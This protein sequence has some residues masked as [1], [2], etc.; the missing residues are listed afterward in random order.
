MKGN[1]QESGSR[2][3]S[4]VR[5]VMAAVSLAVALYLAFALLFS[6]PEEERL[7]RENAQYAR[8]YAS[9]REREQLIGD[10]TKGLLEKDGAIYRELFETEA[11]S[12]NPTTAADL[13]PDSDSLS[14]SFYVSAASSKTES[15]MLMAGNVDEAFREIFRALEQRR[16]SVPPLTLPLRGMSYVQTGASAGLKHNPVYKVEMQHDGIDL[17]VPQGEPVYAAAD[18]AVTEVTHSRKGLGNQVVIDHGNGYSTCYALLGDIAVQ[19]GRKVRLGQKVG[20]VGVSAG[21]F[22]PHLHYEVRFRGRVLDPVN[23]LFASVSPDDYAKMLYMS[24]ST[25]Q[26]MD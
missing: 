4:V 14:E 12:L 3:G 16:D 22:A 19:R 21:M 26:S 25:A 24:V 1:S 5:H 13:I 8:E 10:V 20:T 18:G 15:L 7:R 9:L 11:P 23:H 2:L 6:T 17:I